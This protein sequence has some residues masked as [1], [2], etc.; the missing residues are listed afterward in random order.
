VSKR[1]RVARWSELLGFTEFVR[2]LPRRGCLAVLNYHRIGDSAAT[3]Y[4]PG[5]FSATESDFDQ[6]VSLIKCLFTIVTLEEAVDYCRRGRPAAKS[7]ALI[8]FDDGYVDNY[9]TAFSVLRAHGVQGTFF[10][11][12]SFIGTSSIPWWDAIAWQVKTSRLASLRLAYP[13]DVTIPLK[14][15]PHAALRRLL[16]IYKQ[17]ATDSARFI[18]QLEEATGVACPVAAHDRLFM[19]WTEAA[20]MARA[21]MAIGSHT[22]SHEVLSKMSADRQYDEF[23]TSREMLRQRIGIAPD[24]LAFPVGSKTSFSDCTAACL[25]RAG[26]RAGFSFYGGVN[27]CGS[28]NPFDIRR[29]PGDNDEGR[30][31]LRLRLA[32]TAATGRMLI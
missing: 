4:D 16:A 19:N 5:T 24:T 1:E 27:R 17:P 29:M 20:E 11:P 8:T 10:L 12:T 26:Y 14:P 31:T 22:H 7:L 30:A 21:G 2:H 9:R 6:H 18:S 15:D 32:L 3:P 23:R 28:A 25:E 13:A